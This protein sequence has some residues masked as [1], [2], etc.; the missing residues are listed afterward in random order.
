MGLGFRADQ[1]IKDLSNR[2]CVGKFE[3]RER[4]HQLIAVPDHGTYFKY[5]D[6][7]IEFYD[8]CS[9]F[10]WRLSQSALTPARL[11]AKLNEPRLGRVSV[12]LLC[13]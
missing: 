6:F 13:F 3:Q 1:K 2:D 5:P 10:I 4:I 11:S 12:T 7:M 9:K 8:Q